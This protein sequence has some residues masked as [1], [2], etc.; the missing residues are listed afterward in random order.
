MCSPEATQ[1]PHT[2]TIYAQPAFS[3]LARAVKQ[4]GRGMKGWKCSA[5]VRAAPSGFKR[6]PTA[7]A[8]S[9]GGTALPADLRIGGSGRHSPGVAA[10]HP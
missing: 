2:R 4:A 6:Y 3:A 10:T 5:Q 1:S 7:R 8:A 9:V